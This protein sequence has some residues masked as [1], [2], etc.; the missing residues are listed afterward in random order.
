MGFPSCTGHKAETSNTLEKTL[1]SIEGRVG[2][3]GPEPAEEKDDLLMEIT[4]S[5]V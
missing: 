3:L 4:E 2:N 5:C 1:P